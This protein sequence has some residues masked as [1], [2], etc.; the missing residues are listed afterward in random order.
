M[1][2]RVTYIIIHR[3]NDRSGIIYNI[4]SA[5]GVNSLVLRASVNQAHAMPM[6]TNIYV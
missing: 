1:G 6:E 5:I 2:T 3:P 4:L